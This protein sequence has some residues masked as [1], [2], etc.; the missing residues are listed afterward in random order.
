MPF[1]V[2]HILEHLQMFLWIACVWSTLVLVMD[3][4]NR[5]PCRRSP[6]GFTELRV[7]REFEPVPRGSAHGK[8]QFERVSRESWTW[9]HLFC[10]E[11]PDKEVFCAR[12][13]LK[14]ITKH[15]WPWCNIERNASTFQIMSLSDCLNSG[16]IGAVFHTLQNVMWREWNAIKPAASRK[17][18]TECSAL[19]MWCILTLLLL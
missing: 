18:I 10:R 15:P 14:T 16:I 9:T 11:I 4:L 2:A 3:Y 1:S 7:L 13:T 6:R 5:W 8:C 17:E 19:Q 12:L